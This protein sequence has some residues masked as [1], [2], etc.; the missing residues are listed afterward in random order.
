MT[1]IIHNC[2]N[3]TTANHCRWHQND[4]YQNYKK[5][6][7]NNT[8]KYCLKKI[9]LDKRQS[10]ER[11]NNYPNHQYN[12]LEKKDVNENLKKF[13]IFKLKKIKKMK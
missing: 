2:M 3:D 9:H 8:V 10:I 12:Y 13:K 11:S 1:K 5:N 6:C 4:H 7:L